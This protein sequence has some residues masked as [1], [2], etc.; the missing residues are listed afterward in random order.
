MTLCDLMDLASQAALSMGTLQARIVECIAM[1]FFRGSSQPR[2]WTRLNPA[3]QADSLPSETP[4]KSMRSHRVEHNWV[5]NTHTQS[6]SHAWLVCDPVNC[7]PPGSSV[8]G[9][10]QAILEWVAHSFSR[11]SS[12]PRGWTWVS[13]LAG[14]FLTT[15][16][17]GRLTFL[18][19]ASMEMCL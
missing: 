14:G 16:P 11:G 3:L 1:P 9:L 19:S 4:G 7:S 12:W 18:H 13:C 6:L 2:D 10:L 17:P 15:E 8:H 5:T